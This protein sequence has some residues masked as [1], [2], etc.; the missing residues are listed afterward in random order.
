[1][2]TSN[3]TAKNTTNLG[4]AKTWF[5]MEFQLLP[6]LR[7]KLNKEVPT[8]VIDKLNYLWKASTACLERE[9][10]V[11]SSS[12][13]RLTQSFMET[14]SLHK[15][16]L[17]I[18]ILEKICGFCSVLLVPAVT[19]QVRLRDRSRLSRAN[20]AKKDKLK[21]EVVF[22]IS[23]HVSILFYFTLHCFECT[24]CTLQLMPTCH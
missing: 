3:F 24:G 18:Q 20:R 14:A 13:H 19:C 7:T 12:S 6:P 2:E 17:P 11:V 5:N 21:N 4:E 9:P 15:V 8:A 16:D 23:R 1:M 10:V 22:S